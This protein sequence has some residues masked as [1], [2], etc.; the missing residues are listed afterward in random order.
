MYFVWFTHS[1]N[2]FLKMV[3]EILSNLQKY[4]HDEVSA[5]YNFLGIYEIFNI[6]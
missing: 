5:E 6:D 2:V 3:L 1:Q 4:I